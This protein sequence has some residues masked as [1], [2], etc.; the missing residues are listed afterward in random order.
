MAGTAFVALM[1]HLRRCPNLQVLN[2]CNNG[3]GPQGVQILAGAWPLGLR[4]LDLSLNALG[5][6]G[7]LILAGACLVVRR[8]S[9]GYFSRGG[10]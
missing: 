8:D 3:I 5:P 7:A 6:Q 2:L 1:Q 9:K 10:F 4:H